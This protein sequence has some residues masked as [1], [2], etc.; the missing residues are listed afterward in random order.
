MERDGFA[1]FSG[2]KLLLTTVV[3]EFLVKAVAQLFCFTGEN[4]SVEALKTL[5]IETID[6][7]VQ[8]LAQLTVSVRAIH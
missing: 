3:I 6:A 8:R 7:L 5:R 2:L 4:H 1:H